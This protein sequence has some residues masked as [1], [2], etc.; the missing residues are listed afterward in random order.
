M[1]KPYFPMFVDLSEKKVLVAG[2]G[3]IAARRIQ[4][5][6]AFAG[7]ITVVA[8]EVTA[9][10]ESLAEEGRITLIRRPFEAADLEGASVALAATDSRE[11]NARVRRLCAEKG[12]AVNV[13]DAPEECD[14]FFPGVIRE[15]PVVVGVTASG[16]DHKKARAVTQAIRELFKAPK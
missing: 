7:S 11:V 12:I 10:L 2:G 13:I 9:E 14:F 5:L 8:P 16:T 3:R 6:C 15:G 4:T 1:E